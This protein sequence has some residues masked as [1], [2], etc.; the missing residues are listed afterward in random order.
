MEF[1][2]LKKYEGR[3]Y[4][5]QDNDLYLVM[6]GDLFEED[7][8]V[9]NYVKKDLINPLGRGI[10]GNKMDITI[11]GTNV[12][13]SPLYGANADEYAI[14]IDRITLLNV[15]IQWQEL[16]KENPDEII[17]KRVNNIISLESIFYQV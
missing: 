11:E 4:I 9:I 13:I 8:Y 17:I 10:T 2:I 15:I 14:T 6:L 12:V 5:E 1:V 7:Q 3:Y 16:I